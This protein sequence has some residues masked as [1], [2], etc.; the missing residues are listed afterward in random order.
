MKCVHQPLHDHPSFKSTISLHSCAC[1]YT[2]MLS[3]NTARSSNYRFVSGIVEE[4]FTIAM[5]DYIKCAT[6]S[7]LHSS[8]FPIDILFRFLLDI[9]QGFKFLCSLQIP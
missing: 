4:R 2:L 7:V 1:A 6:P 5:I 8:T 9:E 3:A